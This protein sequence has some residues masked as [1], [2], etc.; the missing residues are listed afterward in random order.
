MVLSMAQPFKHP[1]TGV[2]WFRKAVPADLRPILGLTE[3]RKTLG[4][5][6]PARARQAHA[7]LAAE[8]EA[9]WRSLRAGTQRLTSEQVAALAG[10]AYA[11]ALR[12][13]GSDPGEPE[14][15]EGSQGAL[16]EALDALDEEG[17]K[18][19][20]RLEAVVGSDVDALLTRR[21][22]QV[23]VETRQRLLREVGLAL[24]HVSTVLQRRGHG[25]FRPDPEAARFP[26]WKAPEAP[27]AVP[28][29]A[30]KS[31]LAAIL[32]DWWREAQATGR[33][34][35][36]FE[37]YSN[38]VKAFTAYLKHGDA[39]RVTP[40][41]VIGFKDYRLSSINP[42]TGLPISAKTVKDSDLA[43]LKTLFG[44]ALSNRRVASNP[45]AGVTIKLGKPQV[46]RDKWFTNEEAAALLK[47]A[48]ART[49]G[50]DAPKT[51]AAKRWVPWLG[52]Y[53]GARVGELAQLRKEDFRE[54]GGHW[55]L[56]ITPDAGTV[57]T[58]EARDVVLH[59]HLVEKGFPAFVQ[60]CRGGHLF[61]TPGEDGDVLGP[62]QGLK[63]RLAETARETVSD[64]RVQPNHGW[65]HRFTVKAAEAGLSDSVVDAIQGHAPRTVA[66]A[67][68]RKHSLTTLANALELYPRQG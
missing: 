60:S 7:A 39:A 41:D 16:E 13:F 33:K 19:R 35:S 15:W 40:E 42:R 47:A 2:Y 58:N 32:E 18:G 21:G 62:L 52:A 1:K 31:T 20:D 25:D 4:T 24:H 26:E 55:V 36:T 43:G 63:N 50:N 54:E 23:D 48:D 53:T 51:F 45:A 30:G 28:K 6:Y 46:Q 65:R 64:P 17:H 27:K 44:W 34:P 68:Y 67:R 29:V 61:L 56:R 22:L 38:T 12:Q 59:A 11:D 9:R 66:D 8:V 37:S 57:K 14:G 5:K 10:E 3:L 49:Q